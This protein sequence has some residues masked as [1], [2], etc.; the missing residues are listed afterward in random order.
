MLYSS[1]SPTR[2]ADIWALPLV[3]DQHPFEVVATDYNESQAQFSPDGTTIAYQSNRTGR[4]EIYLRPF[5]GPGADVQVSTEGGSQARWHPKGKE[6]FYV[7]GDDKLMT[8]PIHLKSDKTAEPGTP[9]GLFATSIGS[10]VLLKYRQQYT[11]LSR[12]PVVCHELGRRRRQRF[13][14]YRAH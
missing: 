11:G 3:G 9:W 10:T 7:G 13:T 8:V 4:D 6:L 5:P 1:N 12:R 2:G 14:S